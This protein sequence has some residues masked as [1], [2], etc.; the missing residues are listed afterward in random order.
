MVE[1]QEA[2]S[3]KL[4]ERY[5]IWEKIKKIIADL[6]TKDPDLKIIALVLTM[7]TYWAINVK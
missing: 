5:L 6:I 4:K 1:S 2:R 7:L 3:K